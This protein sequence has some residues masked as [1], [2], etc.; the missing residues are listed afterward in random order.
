MLPLANSTA[1]MLDMFQKSLTSADYPYRNIPRGIM[2]A[3]G[4]ILIEGYG[5]PLGLLS[6][7]YTYNTFPSVCG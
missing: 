7:R 4:I 3:V 1:P 6:R 5:T 2:K